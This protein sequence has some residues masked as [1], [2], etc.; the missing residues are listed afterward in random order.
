MIMCSHFVLAL[1][2]VLGG[3]AV[4]WLF[5]VINF[6][7]G[8]D[9][10]GLIRAQ[11]EV[12]CLEF[13]QFLV[14]K[15][16]FLDIIPSLVKHLVCSSKRSLF[17]NVYAIAS[18]R[19]WALDLVGVGLLRIVVLVI[20]RTVVLRAV[21]EVE[22]GGSLVHCCYIIMRRQKEVDRITEELERAFGWGWLEVER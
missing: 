10:I 14:I 15:F 7:G 8:K 5:I 17:S 6:I 1:L 19:V 9:I 16:G 11:F 20:D 12:M 21:A 3:L 18:K 2:L 13:M 22:M 4:D